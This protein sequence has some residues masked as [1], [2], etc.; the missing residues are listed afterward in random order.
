MPK[1]EEEQ[2]SLHLTVMP[3]TV[4]GTQVLWIRRGSSANN[5]N[6]NNMHIIG[7]GVL[8]IQT[9]AGTRN[10]RETQRG[11]VG[12]GTDYSAPLHQSYSAFF[13]QQCRT[14]QTSPGVSNLFT[15]QKVPET[16]ADPPRLFRSALRACISTRRDECETHIHAVGT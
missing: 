10:W 5:N 2:I 14:I 13:G 15:M 1:I 7:V 4:S 6:N 9:G 3:D 12:D 8:T 11:R 16:G